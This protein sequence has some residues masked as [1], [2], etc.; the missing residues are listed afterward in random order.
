MSTIS[1]LGFTGYY[2][3]LTPG[4]GVLPAGLGQAINA[5]LPDGLVGVGAVWPEIYRLLPHKS[6][7]VAYVSSV[8]DGSGADDGC[9]SNDD[10]VPLTSL[11]IADWSATRWI[12]RIADA[13]GLR[14]A[15]EN[16]GYA[17]NPASFAR[18]YRSSTPSGMMARAYAQAKSCGLQ[19]LYWA[20]DDQ[21]WDGTVPASRFF[22]LT[23]PDAARPPQANG[24]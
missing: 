5:R 14:T 17:S 16:P 10:S 13:Y 18:Q 6:N 22:A 24:S 1:S 19:G 4:V 12:S 21:L 23:S 3:V 2:Q 8:A 20:H 11:A 9:Q 7:V 15:G